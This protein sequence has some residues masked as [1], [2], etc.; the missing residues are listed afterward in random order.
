MIK[1]IT[2]VFLFVSVVFGFS[3]NFYIVYSH[4]LING[5]AKLSQK[6]IDVG[7]NE[8]KQDLDLDAVSYGFLMGYEFNTDIHHVGKSRLEF[9]LEKRQY[10][11]EEKNLDGFRVAF[12]YLV[13]TKLDFLTTNELSIFGKI[14]IAHESVDEL[15]KASEQDLGILL[16]FST[17]NY[18]LG[19]GFDYEFRRRG[20]LTLIPVDFFTTQ[21]RQE[22]SKNLHFS[23]GMKF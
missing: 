15:N 6:D 23:I 21:K 12:A 5:T 4:G 8:K 13:G 2:L 20:A 16:C 1:K 10:K 3:D 19:L 14:G 17:K 22:E 7:T 18:S 11:F 9:A